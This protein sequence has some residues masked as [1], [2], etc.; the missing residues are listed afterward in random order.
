MPKRAGAT[1]KGKDPIKELERPPPPTGPMEG[2]AKDYVTI[3]TH[4]KPDSRHN[5]MTDLTTDAR[6][7]ATAAPPSEGEAI[8]ELC[9]SLS[10]VLGLR[11]S[12][13]VLDKGDKSREKM[14]EILEKLKRKPKKN[15]SKK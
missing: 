7:V 8:A 5:A 1:T 15:K 9:G 2:D 6:S 11:K 12:D 3:A 4:A 10:K 14:E 13:V